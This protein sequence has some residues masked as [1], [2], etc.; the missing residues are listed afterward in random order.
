[1][2]LLDLAT[3]GLAVIALIASLVFPLGRDEPPEEE[4]RR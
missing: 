2:D 3:A 1:M 4:N